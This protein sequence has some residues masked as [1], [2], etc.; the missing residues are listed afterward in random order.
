MGEEFVEQVQACLLGICRMPEMY[1]V[2]LKDSRR[3]LLQKFPYS[4]FYSDSDSTVMI[5]AVLHNARDPRK[6]QTRLT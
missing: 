2:E 3:A 5:Q 1:A 4:V 6:W